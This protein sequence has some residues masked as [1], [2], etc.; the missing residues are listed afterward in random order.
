MRISF[1]CCCSN[2]GKSKNDT[3]TG[4]SPWSGKTGIANNKF[5]IQDNTSGGACD[6]FNRE[7]QRRRGAERSKNI[8]LV[9]AKVIPTKLPLNNIR[10]TV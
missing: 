3:S 7:A 4:S 10:V 5:N 8:F 1:S 2:F 9:F 6:F